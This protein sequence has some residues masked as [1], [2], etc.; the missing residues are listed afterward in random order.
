M[1]WESTALY[2]RLINEGIRDRM[3]QLHSARCVLV[4]VD[5][6]P[7]ETLQQ[8]G[9]WDQAGEQLARAARQVEAGGADFLLLCTNTMHKVAPQ[10]EASINIPFI[11]LADATARRIR[12][13]GVRTVG[14]LGTRFTMEQA[15][16]RG[17][18]EEHGLEVLVPPADERDLIH[19]VIYNELCLGQIHA[20]SRAAYLH[21]MDA[22][23]DRGA[24]G[25]IAG[26][27]EIGML[28]QQT[29]TD[30]PLFDTTAIH[31][32]AAVAAALGEE[33]L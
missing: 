15:F 19:R 25:I 28:V 27:T 23:R 33:A 13:R 5:F 1:S 8:Q 12:Q 22:L 18:L 16:Y 24:E 14:L 17:R 30:I 10:I 9:A 21:S 31:A 29:D 6:Q 32:E 11:H 3:G 2:Y 26:C 4:S 20:A 7:I